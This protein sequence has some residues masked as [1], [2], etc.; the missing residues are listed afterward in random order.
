VKGRDDAVQ[1]LQR[2]RYPSII[3]GSIILLNETTWAKGYL[4]MI[5][6]DLVFGNRPISYPS[7]THLAVLLLRITIM[8]DGVRVPL[9]WIRV[10]L[11]D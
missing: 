9:L 10:E 5:H 2:Q 11:M 1:L 4:V 3:E 7:H 6:L 8:R